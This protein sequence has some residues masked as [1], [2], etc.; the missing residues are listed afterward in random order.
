[1]KTYE[2]EVMEADNETLVMSLLQALEKNNIVKFSTKKSYVT[3][4][5][6]MSVDEFENLIDK[7][8]K[9]KSYTYEEARKYLNL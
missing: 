4:G 6:P 2:V 3:P 1:M 7:S 8:L 5:E 9:S